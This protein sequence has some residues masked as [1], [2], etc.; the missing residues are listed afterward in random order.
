MR[1]TKHRSKKID[2]EEA[3]CNAV[4]SVSDDAMYR[5]VVIQVAE[6]MSHEEGSS[7]KINPSVAVAAGVVYDEHCLPPIKTLNKRFFN[8]SPRHSSTTL[9]KKSLC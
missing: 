4:M 9:S 1:L 6:V 7:V 5:K 8:S 2:I 3:K